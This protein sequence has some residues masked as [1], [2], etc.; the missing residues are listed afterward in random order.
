[1]I[2]E[3]NLLP[4]DLRAKKQNKIILFLP[5]LLAL[6]LPVVFVLLI[7][8][9]LFMGLSVVVKTQQYNS[10]NKKWKQFNSQRDTVLG[11]KEK[12]NVSSHHASQLYQLLAERIAMTDKLHALSQ[13]LPKGIWFRR[14]DLKD[15]NFKLWG[16]VVSLKNVHMRMLNRF[17]NKLKANESFSK[18][19]VNFELGSVKM[20]TRGSF[21]VMDFVLEGQLR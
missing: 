3:I 16:T 17:I 10:V 4:E 21:E 7:S 5:Q 19:F 14:L 2:I 1:M 8:I 15:K 11:W 18:D 9:H 6:I 20:H 13:S 12:H